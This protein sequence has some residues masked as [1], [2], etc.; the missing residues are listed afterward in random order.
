MKRFE[1]RGWFEETG[2][3]AA[4]R[5][6][7]AEDALFAAEAVAAGGVVVIEIPL[8]VPQAVKVITQLVKTIP[9][10][11]VGAGGVR[12]PATAQ[13]VFRCRSAVSDLRWS[14]SFRHRV[15]LPTGCGGHPGCADPDGGHHRMG[16][17]IRFRQ[18][19]ALCTDWR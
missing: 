7:S 4:V 13:V 19:R 12:N 3:I 5:V 16:S 17:E 6:N 15:R 9:G 8:T 11:V 1:V 18:G 14:P 2:I 10:I